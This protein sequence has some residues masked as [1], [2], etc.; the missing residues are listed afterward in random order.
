MP[1]NEFLRTEQ[2]NDRINFTNFDMSY[3]NLLTLNL[4]QLLPSHYEPILPRDSAKLRVSDEVICQALENPAFSHFKLCHKSF[5]FPN[6]NLWKYWDQFITNKPSFTWTNSA[7]QQY[8][9][10]VQPF[11][12][13]YFSFNDIL[14]I[15]AFARGYI[16]K[17]AI[18]L[19]PTQDAYNSPYAYYN[20]SDSKRVIIPDQQN[21]PNVFGSLATSV[22]K[23]PFFY[24]LCNFLPNGYKLDLTGFYNSADFQQ[25]EILIDKLIS[26]QQVSP[27]NINMSD[28]SIIDWRYWRP[29]LFFKLSSTKNLGITYQKKV[30]KINNPNVLTPYKES[31][32]VIHLKFD[33]SFY[34]TDNLLGGSEFYVP[35]TSSLSENDL[36]ALQGNGYMALPLPT[37]FEASQYNMTSMAYLHYLCQG[38]TK[39]LDSLGV[40]VYTDYLRFQTD[41][42]IDAMPYIAYNRFYHEH[43]ADKQ[44]Q[45]NTLDW[46][47]ANGPVSPTNS[48]EDSP[49]NHYKF[50]WCLHHPEIPYNVDKFNSDEKCIVRTRVQALHLLLG[51]G[52]NNQLFSS[53][54]DFG[55]NDFLNRSNKALS[56]T[57]MV[58]NGLLHLQY[59]NFPPDYFTEV[60]LDPLAGAKDIQ[61]PTTITQLQEK[62]KLQDFLNQTAWTRNIKEWLQSQWDSF[63]KYTTVNEPSICGSC[64]V[65]IN[66]SQVLQTSESASTP[67]GTRAGVGS[68]YGNGNLVDQQFGEYGILMTVSYIVIDSMYINRFDVRSRLKS[69]RFDYPLPQFANLGNEQVKSTELQ[70]NPPNQ[71]LISSVSGNNHFL[72]A[73]N[74]PLLPG[75]KADNSLN[76]TDIMRGSDA[77]Y[78]PVGLSIS[79]SES[80]FLDITDTSNGVF[81]YIPRYSIYKHHMDEV[82]GNFLTTLKSWVPTREFS[83]HV[84]PNYCFIS[85]ELA[86]QTSNLLKNFVNTDAFGDDNFLIN[87]TNIQYIRRALPYIVNPKM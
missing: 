44:L 21:C 14:P 35:G 43:I 59:A 11:T 72:F 34:T 69:S 63:S 57:Y 73:G 41:F 16:S 77:T 32:E 38:A 85:Y 8:I 40:P 25:Q 36:A 86:S 17:F 4:G 30:V 51:I 29:Y 65:D 7:I 64:D 54:L 13:P 60:L 71:Y 76:A 58:Y 24:D 3:K 48:A 79:N 67:L 37:S 22:F 10:T 81:G 80:N 15:V 9:D 46:S 1:S 20:T 78:F 39:L 74:T 53:N 70:V 12:P 87:H 19:C 6:T 82:H 42:H 52:L 23:K 26:Q 84:L 75:F 45:V 83:Y 28:G 62:S 55:N 33:D 50:G 61:I 49:S 47:E 2:K 18:V 31:T 68:G 66:I 56:H 27:R 5:Y